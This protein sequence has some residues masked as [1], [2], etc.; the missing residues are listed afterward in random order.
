MVSS[1]AASAAISRVRK[2]HHLF[3]RALGEFAVCEN[4]E[5]EGDLREISPFESK[6]LTPAAIR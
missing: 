2:E 1:R 6:Y 3:K 5:K 4:I